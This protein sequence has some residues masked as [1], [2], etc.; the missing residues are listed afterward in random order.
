MSRTMQC[1]LAV[2]VT[3]MV[4]MGVIFIRNGEGRLGVAQLLLGVVTA[5][6][7]SGSMT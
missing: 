6:I 3:T 2:Q 5:V 1:L 7:Y 4:C